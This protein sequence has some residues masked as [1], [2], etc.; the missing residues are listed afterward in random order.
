MILLSPSLTTLVTVKVDSDR[1]PAAILKALLSF[2]MSS[3]HVSVHVSRYP[4]IETVSQSSPA[5]SISPDATALQK[6]DAAYR[7]KNADYI[8]APFL[9]NH[10][11]GRIAGFTG[12][13]ENKTK[14]AAAM[15]ILMSGSCF[16]Y[17]G[18]EIGMVSGEN[19]DPS[20]RAPMYWNVARDN[21]TTQKPPECT[22]PEE[23]PF[24]SPFPKSGGYQGV[25]KDSKP[26]PQTQR[27]R[28]HSHTHSSLLPPL[29]NSSKNSC[30]RALHY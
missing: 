28:N 22:L 7:G 14:L 10:D 8:D 2:L 5:C 27:M 24:G 15:N 18:E 23:Y 12:R 3:D 1:I 29:T 6:A 17:Y 19:N 16:I 4:F 9:S 30:S 21:G 25:S 20:L 26:Q 13:D 11:C